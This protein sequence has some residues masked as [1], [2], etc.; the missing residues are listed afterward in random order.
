MTTPIVRDTS[1]RKCDG[2]GYWNPPGATRCKGCHVRFAAAAS[3][4]HWLLRPG[5]APLVLEPGDRFTF[6]RASTCSVPIPAPAVSRLHA[7]LLWR[8]GRPFLLDQSTFGTFVGGKPVHEHALADGDEIQ[9]GPFCCFYGSGGAEDLERLKRANDQGEV[10]VSCHEPLLTGFI[11]RAGLGEH[12]QGL[13]FNA[14]TGTLYAAV[15]RREVAWVAVK[16]GVALAAE[17]LGQRDDE[18][19]LALLTLRG[20]RFV[21][22]RELA[23]TEK[24]IEKSITALL[25]EAGRRA[26]EAAREPRVIE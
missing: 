12:L 6:G 25:F 15:A 1:A 19:V 16:N 13:E 5:A 3:R 22:S 23:A 8:D 4:R 21:F 26:D 7:E 10:T 24:R 14:K 9:I 11:P 20:G 17:A 18:A 2:C